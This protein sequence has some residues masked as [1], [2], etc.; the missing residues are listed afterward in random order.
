MLSQLT[1]CEEKLVL[2]H[3]GKS[4]TIG[5]PSEDSAEETRMPLTPQGVEILVAQGHRVL[6]EHGAGL[7]ARFTDESYAA[8]GAELTDD[9]GRVFSSDIVL[10]MRSSGTPMW[11]SHSRQTSSPVQ[12]RMAFFT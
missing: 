2:P 9:S 4:F 11:Y 5:I 6:M 7:A 3:P 12:S 8:A 1:P 10:M